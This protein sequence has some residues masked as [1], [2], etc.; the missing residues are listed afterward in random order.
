MHYFVTFR[1]YGTWLHGD[2]R[3]SVDRN[4][5]RVG[6]P[7]IAP[8]VN[9]Q[10]YRQSLLKTPPVY[11]DAKQRACVERTLRE[12]AAHRGWILHAVNVLSNHVHLVVETSE[13]P[14]KAKP[15]K[16]MADFKSYATRRL[17]EAELIPEIITVWEHHGSTRYLKTEE[18]VQ[19]ACHYVLHC[20]EQ[21]EP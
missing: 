3:G 21:S 19:R 6:E 8:D 13:T 5:N 11:L 9:L 15:E 10:R 1:T 18:A 20:Q 17:R 12:V 16:V 4:H 2:E 14:D 7:L